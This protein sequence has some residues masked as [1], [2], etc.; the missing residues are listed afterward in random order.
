MSTNTEL[1]SDLERLDALLGQVDKLVDPAARRTLQEI[2]QGVMQFHAAAI[3]RLLEIVGPKLPADALEEAGCDDLVS[4]LLALY[5]L[6]PADLETR[7]ERALDQA[8]PYLK[9]HGG[10]VELVG[11]EDET[12]RLRLAGSCHGCPSSA[13][14]I[15]STIEE[16]IRARVPEIVH[17]EVEGLPGPASGAGG[18][19]FVPLA[20]LSGSNGQSR[21]N[22]QG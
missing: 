14:T 3:S 12:V 2:L 4:S 7:I 6:H 19:G 22:G 13:A 11:V 17:I 1:V 15:K 21:K 16:S 9:S 18:P 20:V 5:D 8:R 10:S